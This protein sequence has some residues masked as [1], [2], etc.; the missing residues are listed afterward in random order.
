M[1][2]SGHSLFLAADCMQELRNIDNR[3]F[4]YSIDRFDPAR[5]KRHEH[6]QTQCK[7]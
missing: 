4:E 5:E 7:R 3:K 1:T 6:P 2:L